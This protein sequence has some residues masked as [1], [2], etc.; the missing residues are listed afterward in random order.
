MALFIADKLAWDESDDYGS[1]PFFGVISTALETSLEAA[2]LA[3]M[4]YMED[5]QKLLR[6]HSWWDEARDWLAQILIVP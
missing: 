2:C 5:N 4:N 6:R 1:A 3:Y